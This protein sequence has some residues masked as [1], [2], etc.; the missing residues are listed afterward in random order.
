[1]ANPT[2][3]ITILRMRCMAS[4]EFVVRVQ[5]QVYIT[6]QDVFGELDTTPSHTQ[7]V[8]LA[9]AAMSSLAM[10]AA[11]FGMALVNNVNVRDTVYQDD[12]GVIHTSVA[13]ADLYAAV[14]SLW[15]PV[16]LGTA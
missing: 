8:A 14:S 11:K 1:M 16:A 2:P 9:T 3:N 10:T 4:P 5:G 15:T 7:R 13:D 12:Y 6:A